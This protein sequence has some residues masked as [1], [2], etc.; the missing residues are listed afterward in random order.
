MLKIIGLLFGLF[1]TEPLS[2]TVTASDFVAYAGQHDVLIQQ[3]I[4]SGKVSIYM[5]AFES[6]YQFKNPV[7]PKSGNRIYLGAGAHV[8]AMPYN[9]TNIHFIGLFKITGGVQDVKILGNKDTKA[10]FEYYDFY[11][12]QYGGTNRFAAGSPNKSGIYIMD[13]MDVEVAGIRFVQCP[14]DGVTVDENTGIGERT[15]NVLVRDIETY[16]CARSGVVITARDTITLQ[17]SILEESGVA[18]QPGQFRYD[19]GE[20]VH[21]EAYRPPLYGI[22]VSN[23]T[24]IGCSRGLKV[25]M[26]VTNN[27][28]TFH[29]SSD[30]RIKNCSF[31]ESSDHGLMFRNCLDGVAPGFIEARDCV[32]SNS[33]PGGIRFQN[34][35]PNVQVKLVQ[36]TVYNAPGA[37]RAPVSIAYYGG[38]PVLDTATLR[39]IGNIWLHSVHVMQ[40]DNPYILSC[41]G[42]SAAGVLVDNVW[43]GMWAHGTTNA[44][45]MIDTT[46][47]N[48]VVTN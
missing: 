47:I 10:V 34:W 7:L 26:A 27:E 5:P 37:V 30:I 39:S 21:I 9:F 22:L 24:T 2:Y 45:Q 14:G 1:G 36:Q 25:S 29:S 35:G 12:Y 15:R 42:S 18:N 41:S 40:N 16:R 3:K 38:D 4:E 48:V 11:A 13:A 32:I 19:Q 44:V 6:A 8:Y 33:A 17:D 28:T 31:L 23:V 46:N 43:G 20:G